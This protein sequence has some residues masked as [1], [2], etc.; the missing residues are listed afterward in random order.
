MVSKSKSRSSATKR[1]KI[2][3]SGKITRRRGRFAHLLT[4]K[5]S[6]RKRVVGAEEQIHGAD[7]K[8][9]RRMLLQ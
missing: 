4:K 2:T 5:S 8:A 1:F 7:A 9:V 6:K 3:G